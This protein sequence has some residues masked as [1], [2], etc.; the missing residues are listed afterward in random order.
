MPYECVTTLATRNLKNENFLD[1][2]QLR[3]NRK[4]LDALIERETIQI[5]RVSGEITLTLT[6][7][8]Q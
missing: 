1:A 7:R 5:G 2:L 3:R 6:N 4:L 8:S